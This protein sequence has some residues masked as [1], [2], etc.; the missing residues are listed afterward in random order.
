MQLVWKI[1]VHWFY[2]KIEITFKMGISI[3]LKIPLP[4]CCP[5][6]WVMHAC[7]SSNPFTFF[8]PVPSSP[9]PLYSYQSV[10]CFCA[11]GSIF[12]VSLFCSL[13]SSYEILRYVSFTAWLISFGMI[14]S[15]SNHAVAKVLQEEV[16]HHHYLLQNLHLPHLS[17]DRGSEVGWAAVS[18]HD[19][20]T[21]D[22]AASA[23]HRLCNDCWLP[24]SSHLCF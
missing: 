13:D 21:A 16:H 7:S 14:V 6:P 8:Q 12:L 11:S 9:F 15:R 18:F 17:E 19:W 22:S 4:R 24:E 23:G 20:P 10:P 3:S 2:I 1:L 5:C